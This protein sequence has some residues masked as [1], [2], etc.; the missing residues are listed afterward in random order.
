MLPTPSTASSSS[1]AAPRCILTAVRPSSPREWIPQA[2]LTTI[3]T[4]RLTLTPLTPSIDARIPIPSQPSTHKQLSEENP[5]FITI[6][7]LR[8]SISQSHQTTQPTHLGSLHLRLASIPPPR[9]PPTRKDSGLSLLPPPT[10]LSPTAHITITIPPHHRGHGYTQETLKPLLTRLFAVKFLFGPP[11]SIDTEEEGRGRHCGLVAE[12][13]LGGR[14]KGGGRVERVLVTVG[15]EEGDE[16]GVEAAERVLERL[17][18]ENCGVR[19][20]VVVEEEEEEEEEEGWMVWEIERGVFLS[21]W[22]EGEDEE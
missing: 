14:R 3:S 7:H 19:G 13:F 17:G 22:V 10:T 4:P 12:D 1:A 21:K 5:S 18:F 20:C 11:S 15:L 6:H 8:W 9:L 16:E 2:L